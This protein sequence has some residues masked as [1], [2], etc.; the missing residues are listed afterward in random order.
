MEKTVRLELA[1]DTDF[2]LLVMESQAGVVP[3]SD[4]EAILN[5]LTAHVEHDRLHKRNVFFCDALGRMH[6]LLLT[7]NRRGSYHGRLKLCGPRQWRIL[8]RLSRQVDGTRLFRSHV[9]FMG[10]YTN[11]MLLASVGGFDHLPVRHLQF[12]LIEQLLDQNKQAAQNSEVV[13]R[14]ANG[15][16]YKIS[17]DPTGHISDAAITGEEHLLWVRRWFSYLHSLTP[18]FV[19]V[20]DT[21]QRIVLAEHSSLT[22]LAPSIMMA[23]ERIFEA[24]K[25]VGGMPSQ[26]VYFVDQTGQAGELIHDRGEFVRVAACSYQLQQELYALVQPALDSAAGSPR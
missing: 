7:P 13:L 26:K 2:L 14:Q 9:R 15:L 18:A 10:A 23:P 3:L 6:Q 16:F 22:G 12:A 1:A 17:S 4:P 11:Q 5:W 21:A 20:E 8:E 25:A 19:T 24:W